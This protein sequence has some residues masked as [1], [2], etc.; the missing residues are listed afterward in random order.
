MAFTVQD[1]TYTIIFGHNVSAKS[2]NIDI[3]TNNLV[4]DTVTTTDPL[5]AGTY[6]ITEIENGAFYNCTMLTGSLTIGGSV[7]SIG[8]SAFTFCTGL[9]G[10]LTIGASVTSIDDYAF[11]TCSALTGFITIPEG[12][13]RIGQYTFYGLEALIGP[14]T[15]PASVTVIG[16]GAF[17][18]CPLVSNYIFLGDAPTPEN[19]GNNIFDNGATEATITYTLGTTGWSETW[20]FVSPPYEG[21]QL[22]SK[23]RVHRPTPTMITSTSFNV[24]TTNFMGM[25]N[26]FQY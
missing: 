17:N 2:S 8:N 15:I 19:L 3:N 18:W 23:A 11:S 13:T 16:E 6:I 25:G 12:V 4:L 10:S 21:T 22:V 24:F 20:P 9:T 26:D 14:I 5:Y 1:I 7:T